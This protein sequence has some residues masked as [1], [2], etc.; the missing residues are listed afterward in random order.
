MIFQRLCKML[1]VPR[2]RMYEQVTCVADD[3][4]FKEVRVGHERFKWLF[5]LIIEMKYF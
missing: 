4:V 2:I 3:N 1:A 5:L